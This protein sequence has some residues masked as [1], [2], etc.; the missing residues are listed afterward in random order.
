MN[1][2]TR[3]IYDHLV[4]ETQA[5][6]RDGVVAQTVPEIAA[7]VGK[8]VRSVEY[9]LRDLKKNGLVLERKH[10]L[11]RVKLPNGPGRM[12][13]GADLSGRD[14][15]DINFAGADLSGADLTGSDLRGANL[16]G[17][18]LIQTTL[19][20]VDLEQACLRNVTAF[21]ADFTG[22][23]VVDADGAGGRFPRVQFKGA[24]VRRFRVGT[25]LQNENM[26]DHAS[27]DV[28]HLAEMIGIG[29]THYLMA[30]WMQEAMKH[31]SHAPA[32]S[33]LVESERYGC[34]GEYLTF[35]ALYHPD[36]LTD[37]ISAGRNQET[38][39]M[40]RQS[41]EESLSY[42]YAGLSGIPSIKF[43]EDLL[44]HPLPR[45]WE[46][47]YRWRLKCYYARAGYN[48]VVGAE[49]L[50]RLGGC[51]PDQWDTFY[52]QRSTEQVPTPKLLKNAA[53]SD[54]A[55]VRRNIERAKPLDIPELAA[56]LCRDF[57]DID[58]RPR[59]TIRNLPDKNRI[60]AS[61]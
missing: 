48:S 56:K 22:A 39:F 11:T 35:M 61:L 26:W 19:R 41:M 25:P 28:G 45:V 3:E 9:A 27:V 50:D 12:F 16:R 23:N 38:D 52:K 14:L 21:A 20:E 33:G 58:S 51:P 46:V 54:V 10:R 57:E 7:T 18:K 53:A 47:H 17:A 5:P 32:I 1:E 37:F 8:S 44:S 40:L 34:W 15:R 2:T 24:T 60:G 55:K 36:Y 49:E 6:I 13:V 43:V 42:L 31:H 29:H 59:R 30:V 4:R